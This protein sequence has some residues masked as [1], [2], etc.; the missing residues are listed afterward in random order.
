LVEDVVAVVGAVDGVGVAT[1]PVLVGCSPEQAESRK[2]LVTS[3]CTR[4]KALRFIGVLLR[5]VG[6][7][8]QARSGGIFVF[9]FR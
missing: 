9:L 6:S 7:S 3:S 5:V 2:R 4:F 1:V 8:E